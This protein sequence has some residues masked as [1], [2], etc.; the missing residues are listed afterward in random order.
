MLKPQ[1]HEGTTT[2]LY[3]VLG[4]LSLFWPLRENLGICVTLRMQLQTLEGALPALQLLVAWFGA[5]IS[6]VS[7]P[8]ARIKS[9]FSDWAIFP[10]GGLHQLFAVGPLRPDLCLRRK[11]VPD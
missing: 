9:R 11:F 2:R 1:G 8:I 5:V 3:I 7:D 6:T 10:A 4:V